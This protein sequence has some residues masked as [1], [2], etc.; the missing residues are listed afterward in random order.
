MRT[1]I[2][3]LSSKLVDDLEDAGRWY[4]ADNPDIEAE[5]GVC[6]DLADGILFQ[7]GI[8]LSH[9]DILRTCAAE[10]VAAGMGGE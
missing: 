8:E 4:H 3:E 10:C 5:F 6:V 2:Q 1:H 9:G 7:H